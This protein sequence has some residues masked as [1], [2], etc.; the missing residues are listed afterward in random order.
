MTTYTLEGYF[1]TNQQVTSRLFGGNA[2]GTVNT[3]QGVPKESFEIA[4]ENLGIGYVRYPAGQPDTAYSEG[5]IIDGKLPE[6]FTNFM[7]WA[8]SNNQRVAVVTPT[9]S[10]YSGPEELSTFTLLA[11]QRYGD[12][13]E[14]FEVGNEYWGSIGEEAYGVIANE[15][16]LAISQGL[17]A[18]DIDIDI[19]VQMA[20]PMGRASDFG[21]GTGTWL[22]RIVDAN[23]TIISQLGSE[24]ISEIDGVVEHYYF[25]RD[26]DYFGSFD[27][28]TN[29]IALDIAIWRSALGGDT[30]VNIT[31]WN[32]KSTNLNQLG[33]KGASTMIAQL[34]FMVDLDVDSAYVWP[35]Q[36]NTT[37]D[38]AGSGEVIVGEDGIVLNTILGATFSM[39]SESL[40]GKNMLLPEITH[41][42][43]DIVF[44]MFGDANEIVLYVS[45]RSREV[46]D[47]TLD[48]AELNLNLDSDLVLAR[49]LSYDGSTASGTYYSGIVGRKVD[50]EFV[51]IDGDEY[52]LNEND[53]QALITYLDNDATVDGSE[54]SVQLLPFEVVELT[55]NIS[56]VAN[57]V[58]SPGSDEIVG[59]NGD[60]WITPGTGSNTIDGRNGIDTV[61]FADLPDTLGR[62]NTEF[63]LDLD[64]ST[65][66]AS[67][68]GVDIYSLANIENATGT[69][70]SDRLKGDAG[71]NVLRGLGD[72]DWFIASE[73]VDLI[74]GGTG[75]DMISYVEWQNSAVNTSNLPNQYGGPPASADVTGVVVD[76]A[77]PSNNTN[78][79]A[80]DTYVSVERITGSG[81]QD[82]F[83]GDGNS[84]EFRGL[85]DYDWFVGSS[86]G[87]ERYFGGDGIDTVTYFQSTAGV[88][89]SLRNGALI[90]GEE[91]GRGTG[92]DAALD[93]Y[94]EIENL[95]GT[96]FN[97]SLTGN[98]GRNILVGLDGDD[99]LFGFG[100]TDYL[101]GGAGN[102]MIDGGGASDYAL[103]DGNQADFSLI[104]TSSTEVTVMGGGGTDQLIDVEYFRF[105]D[106]DVTIW[107]LVIA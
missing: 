82:V 51:M 64:L 19:W 16:V 47:V 91:T 87:R 80:G 50:A 21:P 33:M 48:L 107:D 89:A 8:E 18:A 26:N 73:G 79:A 54:V 13:I 20:N 97:D 44:N 102:D 96:N 46:Q 34:S 9:F 31:E 86:G 29:Y 5:M 72:Y 77:N 104:K 60:D 68:S 1:D 10:S 35:P 15:S 28:A 83:Y 103:F 3:N 62:L 59:S 81:R 36:S 61:S 100:G 11:S 30:T 22:D 90:N 93:L 2:I 74:D 105:D 40:P 6:H 4:V 45:S 92:G 71:D 78:L 57:L 99:F 12:I 24:A 41:S 88:S 85:G 14:A 66:I 69:I 43:S 25:R 17:G 39:L 58:G 37:N 106:G 32:I 67:T 70:F 42:G 63:R 101:K 94:F 7:D 84:N 53:V 56:G 27:P 95:V 98:A 65:G 76:L 75:Q 23:D 55:F 52:Y 38:L 49:K